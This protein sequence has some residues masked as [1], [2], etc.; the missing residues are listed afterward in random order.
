MMST[1]LKAAGLTRPRT[2]P[3][4]RA[5]FHPTD[6]AAMRVPLLILLNFQRASAGRVRLSIGQGGVA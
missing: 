6:I 1:E 5:H 2:R 4:I 3:R